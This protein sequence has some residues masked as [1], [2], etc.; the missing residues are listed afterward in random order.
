MYRQNGLP[1]I[2]DDS[3]SSIATPARRWALDKG[4]I[5]VEYQPILTRASDNGWEMGGVEA[6]PRWQHP[7]RGV[8]PPAAFVPALEKAGLLSPLSDFV[9]SES[10]RQIAAWQ[11][12]GLNVSVAVKLS[13][14]LLAEPDFPERLVAVLDNH[15]LDYAKLILELSEDLVMHGSVDAIEK[16][17]HLH[18]K[19]FG[20]A[21]DGF[22]TG[23]VSLV[24]LYHRL[25]C[26]EFKIDISLVQNIRTSNSARAT[27]HAIIFLGH[28]LGVSVCADGVDTEYAFSFL[29]DAGC[30]RLQG[31]LLSPSLS[32]VKL[33]D[34]AREWHNADQACPNRE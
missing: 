14:A 6:L 13:A 24:Q 12:C 9:L 21:V 33:Q 32:A 28:K 22:S 5:F 4:E 23:Y 30:D 3:H 7:K 34:L 20:L 16:L 19:G 18:T 17:Q 29:T 15:H 1:M 11:Q 2:D 26:N 25:P 27:I 8:L 31:R 10:V